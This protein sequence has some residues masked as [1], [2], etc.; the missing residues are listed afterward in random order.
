MKKTLLFTALVIFAAA[1]ACGQTITVTQPGAESFALGDPCP[2][3][4]TASGVSS[5]VKILLRR[6]G[7]ALVGT[8][9]NNLRVG[10]SPYAWTVASPAV[11]GETYKIHVRATDG[12]AE[13]ESATFSVTGSGGPG[14]PGTISNVHLNYTSPHRIGDNRTISWSASGVSQQLKLQL[15][16][17]G[18]GLVGNIVN[19]LAAGTSSYSWPAGQFIG[20][21]APVGEDYR[22]RVSTVDNA[23]TANSPVFALTNFLHLESVF[24]AVMMRDLEMK[25]VS[26]TF[27]H[28]GQIV[29][30]V[31]N[32]ASAIDQDVRFHL[33]FPELVRDGS[34]T[35]TRRITLA[36]GAEGNIYLYALPQNDIPLRGLLTRVTVDGPTSQITETNEGNNTQE[37]RIAILDISCSAPRSE[38]Q[39]SKLYL[40]DK[41]FRVRFKI[42]VRHNLAKVL[43]NIHVHWTLF[44]PDR[45]LRTYNHT[46]ESLGVG[47]EHVWSVDEKYDKTGSFAA[48]SPTL[49]EATTYRVVASISDPMNAFFDV[50]S[51]NDSSG[52]TFRFPD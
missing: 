6:P 24:V 33:V 51:R 23:L 11:A 45:E 8:I 7:G 35:V 27:G 17:S 29:A 14:A 4:W 47:E 43:S 19:S 36:A 52:F 25:N 26:Y 16:H 50:N 48:H 21:T 12:S 46:I 1:L 18:G 28:G 34:Q 2:I 22:I 10:S 15:I 40:Q 3:H 41:D 20:G 37:A 39:L 42:R 30:R 5:N 44:S 31:K 32:H 49:S 9:A 13:G 38:L